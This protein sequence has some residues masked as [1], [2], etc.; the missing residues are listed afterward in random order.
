[1]NPDSNEEAS[2]IVH[3]SYYAIITAEVRYC[4][5][6]EAPAKLLY[7]EITALSDIKGYCWATNRYLADLY[8]VDI[9]TIQRWLSSLEEEGFI[10]IECVTN[11]FNSKRKIFI[12]HNFQ[13]SLTERQKCHP[14][15]TDLSPPPDKN[16]THSI[17]KS[18]TSIKDVVSPDAPNGD[19]GALPQREKPSASASPRT[20]VL[21]KQGFEAHCRTLDED[22][23][24][25][26]IDTAW[27]TY[28]ACDKE[29]IGNHLQYVTGIL[30]KQR[31][32]GVFKRKPKNKTGETKCKKKKE[33]DSTSTSQTTSGPTSGPDTWVNPWR[34]SPCPIISRENSNPG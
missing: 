23:T 11:S 1:M 31:Q 14:P 20:L 8:D 34:N 21:E 32:S 26:E 13:K 10:R 9:R 30:K 22:W 15:M 4:K 17:T 12:N 3:P 33:K 18:T 7:G 29:N 5:N 2:P 28:L 24:L 16:V 6:L 19:A 27:E 25:G